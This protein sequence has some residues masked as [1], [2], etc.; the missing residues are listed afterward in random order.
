MELPQSGIILAIIL[1]AF[2]ILLLDDKADFQRKI[3]QVKT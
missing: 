2:A 3:R 1:A